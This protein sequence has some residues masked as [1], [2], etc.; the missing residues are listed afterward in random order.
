[1]VK[2]GLPLHYQGYDYNLIFNLDKNVVCYFSFPLLQSHF[3][4][5]ICIPHQLLHMAARLPRRIAT[6]LPQIGTPVDYCIKGD[7]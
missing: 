3:S 5:L 6:L 2:T 7:Q 1:M 4:N